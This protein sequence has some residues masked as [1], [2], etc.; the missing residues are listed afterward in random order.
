MAELTTVT[1]GSDDPSSLGHHVVV[2]TQRRE[3]A[4][5]LRSILGDVV[6]A[7]EKRASIG[8]KAAVKRRWTSA[9]ATPAQGTGSLHPV[10][11]ET[12]PEATK[13]SEPSM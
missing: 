2:R 5:F 4:R 10:A 1:F 12:A 3:I 6:G 13:L 9:G 7:S 8:E 11:I